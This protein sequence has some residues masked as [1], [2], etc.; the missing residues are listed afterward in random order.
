[1]K[2][3]EESKPGRMLNIWVYEAGSPTRSRL[4]VVA[5]PNTGKATLLSLVGL[6]AKEIEEIKK[7]RVNR[8]GNPSLKGKL[9]WVIRAKA[10]VSE[11]KQNP[12][13][14][15][16]LTPSTKDAIDEIILPK[17]LRGSLVE[18]LTDKG[19][20][21][22]D[23]VRMHARSFLRMPPKF[24]LKSKV[25][26]GKY[27]EET[28]EAV[29]RLSPDYITW[30]TMNIPGFEMDADAHELLREMNGEIDL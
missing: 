7:E 4:N 15:A 3:V 25:T 16:K 28:L 10:S 9:A 29:I 6:K 24:A 22:S 8:V 26:F 5:G 2:S 19:L 12:D 11:E 27:R 1:M 14:P 20:T 23:F 17:D 18:L 30:C 13:A 21:L